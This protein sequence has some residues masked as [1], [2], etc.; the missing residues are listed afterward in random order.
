MS[1]ECLD[2]ARYAPSQA[3]RAP[4]DLRLFSGSIGHLTA[5]AREA[6]ASEVGRP[7]MSSGAPYGV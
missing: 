5:A 6:T 2:L 7:P 3:P 1:M 4:K